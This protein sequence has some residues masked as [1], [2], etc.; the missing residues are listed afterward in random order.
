MDW[1]RI[2]AFAILI[3][4]HV[5]MVFA[6]WGYHAKSQH[7]ASNTAMLPM[8]AANAWRLTLL[9]VVSGYATRALLGR[10]HGLGRFMADRTRRLLIPLAFGIA[11]I[12]PPQ[13][14]VELVTQHGYRGSY[15]GFWLRD[16]F[17]F[18]TLAGVSLPGWN[19][20]WFVGYLWLYTAVLALSVMLLRPLRWQH[21][22]NH[23]FAGP[24]VLIV[25]F[26]WY[27]AIHSWWFPMAAETHA[28]VDDPMAHL[29]YLPAFLFGFGL[30]RSEAIM[31]AIVRWH[32]LAAVLAGFGY[33][34]V[35]TVQLGWVPYIGDWTPAY[36]I[37][38]AMEQWGAIVALIGV[39]EV[40]WNRDA[41]IRPM[42][43]EAVFPFY[44]VHQ[45]IIVVTAFALMG[46]GLSI[47]A[48]S[49]ILVAATIVGC[50]AFYLIGRRIGPLRPLIGLRGTA[51]RK[52]A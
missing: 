48:E 5:A 40:H 21:V 13:A 23:V 46:L 17:S 22:F 42:L 24:L 44:L 31:A 18:R 15:P 27:G 43:T 45:T 36:G 33:G 19:H 50:F 29:E 16:W 26:L 47:L 39:A 30:A 34:W 7:V 38:H 51:S 14:W 11:V 1:L 2:G 20:L 52:T 3:L 28:L 12:V 49:L 32:R 35:A 4:Y 25:P 6:P 41:A 9:F 37:A 8:L 10:A